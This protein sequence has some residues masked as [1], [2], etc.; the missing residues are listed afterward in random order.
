MEQAGFPIWAWD[1]RHNEVRKQASRRI[2]SDLIGIWNEEYINFARV[3]VCLLLLTPPQLLISFLL[4]LHKSPPRERLSAINVRPVPCF[5]KQRCQHADTHSQSRSINSTVFIPR[6]SRRPR[7]T[8]VTL[9]KFVGQ[10][11]LTSAVPY[12]SPPVNSLAKLSALS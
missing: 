5:R 12:I 1:L 6:I 7:N 8:W 11:Y 2:G 4:R 3:P 10:L 9:I